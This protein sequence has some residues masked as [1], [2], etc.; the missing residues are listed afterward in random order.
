MCF[1]SINIITKLIVPV[2]LCIVGINGVLIAYTTISRRNH[3][4]SS[5]QDY[6]LSVVRDSS[7]VVKSEIG[8]ASNMDFLILSEDRGNR[9]VALTKEAKSD[10]WTEIIIS[11]IL[12]GLAVFVIAFIFHRQI[13]P[14]RQIA[15]ATEKV[16]LGKLDYDEI[17]T[18]DDEIG[19]VNASFMNVAMSLREITT[20]CQAL[21]VG[22]F[23][24][25]V[26]L[27]SSEDV[28]GKAVNLMVE[29]IRKIVTQLKRITEGGYSTIFQPFSDK[30]QLGSALAEM[31]ISLRKMTEENEQ[32]NIL[33]TGQMEL[34]KQMR[35][36]QDLTTLSNNVIAYLCEYLNAPIGAFYVMDEE[37]GVLFMAGSFAYQ[38]RKKRL[39]HFIPGEGLVGQAAVGKQRLQIYDVPKDYVQIQSGL[40]I[41]VPRS[42]VVCPLIF[43]NT[44]KGVIEL[45]S[46][47]DFS[48]IQLEFLDQV[49]NSIAIALNSAQARTRMKILLEQTQEQADLLQ[50]QQEALRKSN[51][52]LEQQASALKQSESRLQTQQEELRQTNEEL[53]EQTQ[54]LEEQK[55]DIQKKNLEL[56]M[57][58]KL[59]EEK[60]G[61]LERTSRY[62]S[63]F[64]ANMSHE[65]RTPLNSILLLSKLVSDNKGGNLTEKQIEFAQTIH[66]SGSDLLILIN[67]VLDLSKVESGKMELR[68]EPV[69]LSDLAEVMKRNFQVIAQ[70]K[71]LDFVVELH[72]NLPMTILTD[73]QRTEQIIK[74]FLSN[75]FKFTSSG[76]VSFTICPAEDI[77]VLRRN[78]TSTGAIA[79]LVSDTG[80]GIPKDK[81]QLVFEAFKQADGT[82]NRKYGGTGLGLSIS[83]ELAKYLGGEIELESQEGKGS[84]FI[85]V[86]PAARPVYP[87]KNQQGLEKKT[88]LLQGAKCLPSGN[89]VLQDDGS[90][91]GKDIFPDDKSVL[92]I[93]DD[94]RSASALVTAILSDQDRDAVLENKRILLVDDDMRNVYAITNILEEKGM[95]V[96]V[97]KNGKEGIDRLNRESNI[98]LVLMDIMMP[99]MDGYE[100][101]KEI[102]KQKRFEKL[103]IIALTAKAMK[104]DRTLCIEAG[105]NDYLAKPF[106]TENLLSMLRAWLC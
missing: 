9:L 65:L 41:A 37:E 88:D 35:G 32:Q 82:T 78:L 51:L 74:N 103:P 2:L 4:A 12:T 95:K 76:R 50:H 102:R 97:G 42:I 10:M 18:A 13:R 96:I 1:K 90:T 11:T 27:K 21:A 101:M 26:P 71:G 49:S 54:L 61:A 48:D 66:D 31:I 19:R 20:I 29:N 86:L 33:K 25:L 55:E 30:D 17:E 83:V 8:N 81:Q 64:L 7:G 57:A 24:Q 87:E 67:E 14:L 89:E 34:H 104:G 15:E 47:Q 75:A 94:S 46:F 91:F 22:D 80:I 99:V 28:L 60:A 23:S 45:G 3:I 38:K 39:N 72:D 16:A 92:M 59:I 62:K 36:E 52:D 77:H 53:Q 100:A 106:E 93:E 44:V 69:I 68:L 105:A 79:F 84:A 5:I 40:G 98:D 58:G 6:A 70:K 73:R 43:D 56:E 63:E 85:L